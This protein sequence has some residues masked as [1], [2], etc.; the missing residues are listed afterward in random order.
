MTRHCAISVDVTG[1]EPARRTVFKT[2]PPYLAHPVI[3]FRITGRRIKPGADG[4][5]L[6]TRSQRFRDRTNPDRHNILASSSYHTRGK[7]TSFPVGP[8]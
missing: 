2:L 6:L 8:S 7:P 4:R 3:L 5:P 1:L